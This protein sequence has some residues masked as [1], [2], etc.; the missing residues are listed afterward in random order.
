MVK[1]AHIP[2]SWVFFAFCGWTCVYFFLEFL[3]FK[4]KKKGGGDV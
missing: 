1:M 3:S 4:I 2:V